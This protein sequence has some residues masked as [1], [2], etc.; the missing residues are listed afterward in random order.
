M[1]LSRKMLKAMSIE[2]DQIDQII[3]A[4]TESTDALKADRDKYKEEA[5]KLPSLQKQIESLKKDI[6]D[7]EG[8][9]DDLQKQV[10]E[11]GSYKEK[12]ENEHNAFEDF[13][14][15]VDAK[16]E[17]AKKAEAYKGLLKEAGV[18]D[19]RIDA[20]MK[21]TQ[22]GDIELDE[23][24]KVKGSDKIVEN[25]KSEWSEFIVTETTKGVKTEEP[26]KNTGGKMT[27]EE[28][29]KIK[30]SNERQKA[31]DDNHELFGY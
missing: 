11:N 18:S 31:I 2:D 1:A 27:K 29:M 5:E 26:P 19:K 14:K 4:H 8:E 21:V 28:I 22:V 20:I 23:E 24:G 25:I 9:R 15:G 12:Y 10:D 7:L 6:V 30:D 13:K 16:A 17:E 3:E